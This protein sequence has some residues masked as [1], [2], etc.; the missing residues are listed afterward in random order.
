MGV[1]VR[2][3][4]VIKEVCMSEREPDWHQNSLWLEN[5][6]LFVLKEDYIQMSIGLYR[7]DELQYLYQRRG[8]YGSF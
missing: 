1:C 7:T 4:F 5:I 2:M 3:V 8:V 6:S